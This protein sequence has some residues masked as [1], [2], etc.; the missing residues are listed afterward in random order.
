VQPQ[1]DQ[2]AAIDY[3]QE[4]AR[5]IKIPSEATETY[6]MTKPGFTPGIIEIIQQP[7][8]YNCL[9]D[10]EI[11]KLRL[12]CVCWSKNEGE[13]SLL[14]KCSI[15]LKYQHYHCVKSTVQKPYEC[16]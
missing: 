12:Q 9:L 3:E 4:V 14:I 6:N 16:P 5:L 15:C 7:I 13:H 2:E 8:K 10:K 11:F 1:K